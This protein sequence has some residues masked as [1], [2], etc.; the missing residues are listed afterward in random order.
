MPKGE[1]DQQRIAKIV[2][3]EAEIGRMR[4]LMVASRATLRDYLVSAQ[5]V[6]MAS[7]TEEQK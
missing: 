3:L 4:D 2:D 7:R 1:T 5:V 6:G